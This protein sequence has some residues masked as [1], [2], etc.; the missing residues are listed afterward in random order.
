MANP[1]TL[2]VYSPAE[3]LAHSISHGVGIVLAIAGLAVLVTQA[4]LHGGALDVT[5]AVVFGTTLILLYSASTLYHA[6]P[7]LPRP[8]AKR[9]LRV[10]DH[11][12]IYLLIAGTY[13]PF[14]LG[15]LLGPWGWS[16]FAVVW[17]AAIVGILWKSL[18]FGRAPIFSVVLYVAMGWSVVVAFRPLVERLPGAGVSLLVAGGVCYTFGLVFF[19]WQSL[20]FHHFIWHLFVLA[21]S[22]FHY[23]AVLHYVIPAPRGSGPF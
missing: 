5:S 14:T 22:L 9:V 15:P 21:G 2:P 18:A 17:T 19:A 4:S 8:R 1:T 3:E 7:S 10:I 6:I 12:S 13:T 20:R 23:F 11:S 16:L